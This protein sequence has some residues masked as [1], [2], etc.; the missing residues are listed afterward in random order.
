M[1]LRLRV[2]DIKMKGHAKKQACACGCGRE[3]VKNRG[4]GRPRKWATAYCRT[5]VHRVKQRAAR[6][7]PEVEIM[8]GKLADPAGELFAWAAQYLRVP[9]GHPKASNAMTV[10]K[11]GRA[12]LGDVLNDEIL[13]ALLC[14]AR[15]NAKSALVA[16]LCLGY[17][18][19]PIRYSG[20]RAGV[21]SISKGKARELTSQIEAIALSSGLKDQ[22]TFRRTPWPGRIESSTG[23]VEIMSSETGGHSSS[24]DLSIIDELGIM[25]EKDRAFI[26]SMRSAVS[27]K[28]GKFISLSVYGSGPFIPEIL[29]RQDD[30]GMAVHLYQ[31]RVDCDL[32]DREAWKDAN[33]GLGTIKSLGYMKFESRRAEKTPSDESFFRSQDLNL[34]GSASVE[35]ICSP[36]DWK[37]CHVAELPERDGRCVVGIDLGGSRSMTAAV[38]LW[39]GT[40]RIEAYGA[41]PSVP[42]LQNRAKKDR[43]PY[44]L[45]RADGELQVYQGR[46]VPVGRFLRGIRDRLQGQTVIGAGADRYRRAETEQFLADG[47]LRWPMYWRGTGASATADGSADV[48][49]FQRAVLGRNLKH[50]GGLLLSSAIADSILRYDKAGNPALDKSRRYGRIDAVSAGVIAA[51]L[52]ERFQ[53]SPKY[54]WRYGGAV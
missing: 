47:E 30:P 10:P 28:K 36:T 39:P 44:T 19:G 3:F 54:R 33:P 16:I 17:L 7:V 20:F 26:N 21:A 4:P 5:K 22:L 15:K 14:V 35:Q 29:E 51:G 6:K 32:D 40:G 2:G 42:K 45:M 49:A 34:E 1:C 31:A 24:F 12:F 38:I 48:R 53:A 37:K 52:A 43:Q 27:A 9:P 25:G 50:G 13:E 18:V 41:F 8:P 23:L 11:F 46:V